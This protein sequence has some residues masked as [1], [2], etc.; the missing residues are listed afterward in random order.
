MAYLMG[1]PAEGSPEADTRARFGFAYFDVA[2]PTAKGL[3]KSSD[4]RSGALMRDLHDFWYNENR[5]LKPYLL[6]R[7]RAEE[8]ANPLLR[9]LDPRMSQLVALGSPG[10]ASE[11]AMRFV[12]VNNLAVP[13]EGAGDLQV[14]VEGDTYVDVNQL[15]VPIEGDS[16]DSSF[17]GTAL[18][19]AVIGAVIAAV[20]ALSD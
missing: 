14:A 4:P 15:R 18:K 13:V 7:L 11:N 17:M 10:A 19:V 8:A 5:L 16:G 20:V 2:D 12:T 3:A 6:A 1:F 9:K